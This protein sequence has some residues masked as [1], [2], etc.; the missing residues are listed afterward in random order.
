MPLKGMFNQR[1]NNEL[2]HHTLMELEKQVRRINTLEV[3]MERFLKLESNVKPLLFLR[4][5]I[6]DF[7]KN[8]TDGNETLRERQQKKMVSEQKIFQLLYS[9]QNRLDQLTQKISILEQNNVQQ[10]YQEAAHR[11]TYSQKL[12]QLDERINNMEEK[13]VNLYN[14]DH[15][16]YTKSE[17]TISNVRQDP[18]DPAEGL[19]S[20]ALLNK[21]SFYFHKMEELD[22]RITSLE[23]NTSL[24]EIK[25]SHNPEF[26]PDSNSP[27]NGGTTLEDSLLN[28][29]KN[30]IIKALHIDK[31]FV[32]KYEQNNTF[33]Q[34]GIK[35]LSGALNIGATYGTGHVPMEA[36]EK[37]KQDMEELKEIK[38]S[39]VTGS[40]DYPEEAPQGGTETDSDEPDNFYTEINIENGPDLSS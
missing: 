33:S 39:S 21:L 30:V 31:L 19:E 17:S 13:L 34:L 20:S 23:N 35:E 28:S 2:L 6:E 40:G 27:D 26:L 9:Y 22:S 5:Q 38:N 12:S 18:H 29:E 4:N 37:M 24:Q 8:T 25:A 1:S 14:Q 3:H 36:N 16:R 11:S 32:D 10:P 7:F 15:V